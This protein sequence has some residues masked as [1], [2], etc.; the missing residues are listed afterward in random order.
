M[1]T[2]NLEEIV[3]MRMLTQD[4]EEY[5]TLL[6]QSDSIILITGETGVG[7]GVLARIIASLSFRNNK[8]FVDIN[9]GSLAESLLESELFGY[10]K[11]AFTSACSDHKGYFEQANTGTIFLDE[12]TETSLNFQTSLLK[13]FDNGCVRR[14]GDTKDTPIDV[15]VIVA[16]NKNLE[17][18]IDNKRFREDLFHRINVFHINIP[19][20]RERISEIPLLAEH[21][22]IHFNK[23]KNK[24]ITISNGT[25]AIMMKYE[26]KGN[27]R[28]LKNAI[29]YAH[30]KTKCSEIR[31]EHLPVKILNAVNSL[32]TIPNIDCALHEPNKNEL[33]SHKNIP[34]SSS[35]SHYDDLFK[36]NYQDAKKYFEK[37]YITNLLTQ[38]KGK[39]K[40]IA[41]ISGLN[42]SSLYKIFKNNKLDKNIFKKKN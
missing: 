12:I 35:L 11:G 14:L 40:D 31:P 3:G 10:K 24:K 6:A 20:L 4:F 16:T 36:M 30:V 29:E 18:E 37:I 7:K 25:L 19:S 26:W 2:L 1:K 5:I 42:R 41:Q 34:N 39:I 22:V 9:C 15:R 17:E 8:P 13:V 23:K 32:T 38:T 21:Y 33:I 27:I 28:E